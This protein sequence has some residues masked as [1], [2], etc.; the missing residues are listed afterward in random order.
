VAPPRALAPYPEVMD[1]LRFRIDNAHRLLRWRVATLRAADPDA[2]VVAHGLARSLDNMAP[3]ACDDWRAAAEV[4]AWG[5][6]WGSARHGDE[7]WKQWHAVDLVRAGARGTGTGAGTGAGTGPSPDGAAGAGAKPFWH[8]EAYAGALWLQPNVLHKPRDEGRIAR[9]EDIRLWGLQSFA[10]GATGLMYL[11]WRPLLDGP[12]FGAFG[13]YRLDG[14]RTR[15]SE[16][17]AALGRWANAAEQEGLWRARPVRGDVGILVAPE[18]QLFCYAQSGSTD[19]YARSARGAYQ[20]FFEHNAQP[21]WVHV[22]DLDDLVPPGTDGADRAGGGYGLLY[23]PYPVHLSAA[24][25][26][27]LRRWVAAGGALVSE[28]CPGYWG[29]GVRVGTVQPN[30]GLDALFGAREAYAEFTPDLLHDLAFTWQGATVPGGLFL[31]IYAPSS[32]TAAGVFAGDGAGPAAGEVAVV[33]HA[34]ERGRTLLVGTFPGYG[35]YHR[36][37]PGSRRFFGALLDWAGVRPNVRVHAS[38]EDAAGGVWRGVTARLHAP[39]GDLARPGPVYVWVT[40][41]SP[42]ARGVTL[43]LNLPA[44]ARVTPLWPQGA[45]APAIE[46]GSAVAGT[47]LRLEVGGRDAAVLCLE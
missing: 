14:G 4:E 29:D 28:G 24:T 6:T 41:P 11:R 13:A 9:P 46:R 30:L 1:W 7:P 18:S 45:A 23:L 32:G 19:A 35:H 15:R 37:G 20:G 25:A 17:A 21:D 12:L 16:M 40:N 8:A 39:D 5:Y 34:Y 10:G 22:D 38:A 27:R 2:P 26:A 33:E 3:G 36:P 42:D 31:Q 47:R 44:P 43:D